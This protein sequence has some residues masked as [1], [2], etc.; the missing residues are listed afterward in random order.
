M[1]R[2][3]VTQAILD[4]HQADRP[5]QTR[6]AVIGLGLILLTAFGVSVALWLANA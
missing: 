3:D 5:R 6:R 4:A 1:N 2:A